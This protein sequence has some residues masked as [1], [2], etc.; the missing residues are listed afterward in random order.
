VALSIDDVLNQIRDH[1]I[2][3]PADLVADGKK[4]TWAGTPGKPKKKNA[5]AILHEWK[6]PKT[7]KTYIVGVYGCGDQSNFWKVEPTEVEWSPAEKSAWLDRKKAIEKE[8]DEERRLLADSASA[9]AQKLWDRAQDNGVSP[10]LARKQVGNYGIRFSFGKLLVPLSDVAGKLHGLQWIS[11]DGGKVFGTGTVKEGHFHLIG[12][13]TDGKP[14][15]FAEGYATAASVHM[16]TGWPVVVCFDA[17]NLMPVVTAFRKLYADHELIIAGDDDK[18][19]VARLCER[20]EV[21]GVSVSPKD[22]ARA[23]GGLRAMHWDLPDGRKVDLKAEWA[24]DRNEVYY[25]QGAITVDGVANML[26]LENAGRAK[27]MAA[28]KK[29]GGRLVCP[30]FT[31]RGNR[32]SDF[33]DLHCAE[34]I[35]MVLEQL[36]AAPEA[37]QKPN[38]KNGPSIDVGRS[39][40][41]GGGDDGEGPKALLFPYRDDKHN[42]KGIRENV[43]FAFNADPALAELVKLNEFSHRLDKTRSA[44]WGGAPGKW[45]ELDDLRL[46]NYLAEAHGLIVGNPMTIQQAVKMAAADLAYNP[47]QDYFNG[48]V[49][50]NVPRLKHWMVDVLGAEDC[51]YVQKVGVYFLLSMVARVFEPGCQMDYMLVLQGAQGAR[52]SSVLKIL[53]GEYYAGGTF[54]IG[55][56]DSMQVLQGRLLFNFNE[57]DAMGRAE[58]TAVKSFVTERVDVFRAP[59]AQT[60]SEYPRNCVLTGDTNTDDFLKDA[61]GDRRSWVVHCGNID[62]QVM[63]NQR[64]QLFAEAV[65]CYKLGERRYPEKEEEKRLFVPQQERWKFVDVWQDVLSRYVNSTQKTEGFDGNIKNGAILDCCDREFFSTQELF[66]KALNQDISKIDR[67]GSQQRAVGN[68]MKALGFSKYK[69]TKGRVRPWGYIRVLDKAEKPVTAGSEPAPAGNV[70]DTQEDVPA[71]D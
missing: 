24:K 19:L 31:E 16:A 34:G 59:Y 12:T 40:H 55:D 25:I 60:F 3:P 5:W 65:H 36:T 14:L 29:H 43:Y 23:A 38:K 58:S 28:A 33:N 54:R 6:S 67:A 18:H 69:W 52:K 15:A 66:S 30:R 47:M 45:T 61:T 21:H 44:P 46:A 8:A 56:K 10:Y 41:G 22:F 17:G 35:D 11:E 42:I 7:D 53:A 62:P 63:A 70:S 64:D 39:N 68:A 57:M 49:W 32:F 4:F 51:E 71:W 48:L 37:E 27:G 2:E 1:G 26:K 20:L 50:D 13:V 9:K